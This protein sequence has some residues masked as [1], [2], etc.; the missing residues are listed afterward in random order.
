MMIDNTRN[1]YE[2]NQNLETLSKKIEC[3]LLDHQIDLVILPELCSIEYS[4]T[5]FNDLDLL[6]ES[7][8]GPSFQLW[9]RLAKKFNTHVAYSF[10]R[11]T[12][13]GYQIC[14][15]VTGPDASLIGYYDKIHL[16]QYGHSMEKEFFQAGKQHFVFEINGF[17][18][19]MI[20]CADIRI[21]E[22]TRPLVVN[23]NADIILHLSTFSRDNSFFSW[24]HFAV[25]RALE[26]QVYF[27]SLNRAGKEF[28]QSI[29]CPPWIDETSPPTLFDDH[30]EQLLEFHV[31]RSELEQVRKQY[32]FLENLAT[33]D[34]VI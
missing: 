25:T 21:P 3:Y 11:R 31:H 34:A 12:S 29:F 30:D 32:S 8:D 28:G 24:H 19:G 7:L 6:A 26:N 4:R 17:K 16:A 20:I 33:F 2:R 15:A 27:L 5:A 18:L 10:P 23:F 1:V 22:I 9:S 13:D 14:A